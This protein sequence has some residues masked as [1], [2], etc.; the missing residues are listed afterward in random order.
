[1]NLFFRAFNHQGPCIKSKHN[2][3]RL[4]RSNRGLLRRLKVK[5]H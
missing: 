5:R 2:I 1:M 4:A 3:Y